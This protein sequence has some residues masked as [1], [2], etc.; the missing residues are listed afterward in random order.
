MKTLFRQI[1]LVLFC[2]ITSVLSAKV[3]EVSIKSLGAS[4]RVMHHPFKTDITHPTSK[5]I[6][7]YQYVGPWK[8]DDTGLYA[9]YAVTAPNASVRIKN[10][11]GTTMSS[12]PVLP[13]V[14]SSMASGV[15]SDQALQVTNFDLSAYPSGIYKV[16]W[17]SYDATTYNVIT[18]YEFSWNGTV[19]TEYNV[20]DRQKVKVTATYNSSLS[21]EFKNGFGEQLWG[22]YKN[23]DY[24]LSIS[25]AY[26]GPGQS[27]TWEFEIDLLDATVYTTA[28][29][30]IKETNLLY[31]YMLSE[32]DSE[33]HLK[34]VGVVDES[35]K[36]NA[37]YENY[38]G[39]PGVP[40]IAPPQPDSTGIR[41]PIS[42]TPIG[43]PV[44]V[45]PTGD[46]GADAVQNAVAGA[47]ASINTQIAAGDSRLLAEQ[48][49][50]TA[51]IV[52]AIQ[53]IDGGA[54][55]GEPGPG[56]EPLGL[57]APDPAEANPTIDQ[58]ETLASKLPTAPTVVIP[59]KTSSITFNLV[60]PGFEGTHPLTIDLAQWETQVLLFR[61][62]CLACLNI[63][64]FLITISKIRSAFAGA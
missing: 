21:A 15:Y 35:K 38:A 51:A 49:R 28:P 29:V 37:V 40:N 2:A 45:T 54:S 30:N 57:T 42:T 18:F 64:M 23:S 12:Q 25:A 11:A 8:Y 47:A 27:K 39:T 3:K 50:S 52:N 58:I 60:W 36:I 6:R 59:G 19:A 13:S 9:G 44:A 32:E 53:G 16:V 61:G 24:S 26:L 5:T 22:L 17:S 46:V 41:P 4:S 20:P 10:A 34:I 14:W 43:P 55:G 31:G 7:I 62:L 48:Q 1:L 56:D 33:G 63:A